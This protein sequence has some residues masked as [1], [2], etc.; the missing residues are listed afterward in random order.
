MPCSAF[1]TLKQAFGQA[2]Q[3]KEI[4]C[5]NGLVNAVVRATGSY[6]KDHQGTA[7]KGKVMLIGN[8]ISWLLVGSRNSGV[9]LQRK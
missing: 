3:S 6:G 2:V 7:K 5:Y 1:S 4:L 9:Y 8:I